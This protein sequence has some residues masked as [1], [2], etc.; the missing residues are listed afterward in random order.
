MKGPT[1]HKTMTRNNVEAAYFRLRGK[2]WT[3]ANSA[4]FL[5]LTDYMSRELESAYNSA[6]RQRRQDDPEN[7]DADYVEAVWAAN[8]KGFV[9]SHSFEPGGCGVK[10]GPITVSPPSYIRSAL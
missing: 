3:A 4:K 8:P 9:G 5:D 6:S 1:H 2:S 10:T 7:K